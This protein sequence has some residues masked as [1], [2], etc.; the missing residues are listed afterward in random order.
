MQSTVENG[1]TF[2]NPL[3]NFTLTLTSMTFSFI[4]VLLDEI[5]LAS[6]DTLQR[7][8][9]LLD[10]PTGSVTLTERGDASA[11]V[12]HPSFRLFAA[13][14]P[15]TDAGKKDL[16]ASIRSRFSELYVDELL[17]PVELR[18]VASRYLDGVLPT[19]GKPPEHLE[20]VVNA[21]DVY[22]KCRHLAD[23][24]LSDGGGH[25]PRYTMR[26]LSRALSAAKNLVV[27]QRI[28]LERAVYEGFQLS[29]EGAL[30]AASV[31]AVR[32]A[33]KPLLSASMKKSGLEHP[34]R[35][36]GGKNEKDA[37]VLLK[38]FWVKAGPEE[39]TDW[40]EV[41]TTT[42]KARF[43]LTPSVALSL[44]RLSRAL[45]AGPWPVLLEGPT[46]AGKT[47]LVEYIASRC[48]H[49]VIRINNHEHTGKSFPILE[50]FDCQLGIRAK[51]YLNINFE[52]RC[53]R[54]YRLIRS[55]PEWIAVVS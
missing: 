40:S 46:S 55:R 48:G 6:S 5:N 14:N 11:I 38:P 3:L 28:P 43:I 7:L 22:L 50:C 45:A 41:S 51:A 26:T 2:L 44:R 4:R 9:G 52:T 24:I 54:V 10:D 13:M 27:Q 16:P 15:A 1:K 29:F 30:D 36:P 21:V 19:N 8:C 53:S 32:K 33:L 12:R 42:G 35:K 49:K 20:I 31:I 17:D 23:T 37:F 18:V 47:T 39:I 25:K 34:G